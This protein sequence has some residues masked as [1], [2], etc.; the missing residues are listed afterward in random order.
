MFRLFRWS[1][2]LRHLSP[3]GRFAVYLSDA[4]ENFQKVKF[5]TNYNRFVLY[6]RASRVFTPA[7]VFPFLSGEAPISASRRGN[8]RALLRD[9]PSIRQKVYKQDNY[10]CVNC[11]RAGGTDG[12]ASLHADHVIPRSRDGHDRP[13]N[14]RTLCEACHEARHARIFE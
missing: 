13:H 2:R 5:L 10:R 11:E 1:F 12:E 7:Q 8:Q 14:L 6:L 4:A 9:W 3:G